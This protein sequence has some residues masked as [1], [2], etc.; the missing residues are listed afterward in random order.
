MITAW[1]CAD[2]SNANLVLDPS[3]RL[4]LTRTDVKSLRRLDA[5]VFNVTY[6]IPLAEDDTSLKTFLFRVELELDGSV[7]YV[8]QV[9][10]LS[11]SLP[12]SLPLSLSISI[13]SLIHVSIIPSLLLIIFHSPVFQICLT[14]ATS[15]A[16]KW[17]SHSLLLTQPALKTASSSLL[18]SKY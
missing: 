17:I 18:R 2:Y 15:L 14:W 16:S 7:R 3:R 5:G 9:C 4:I 12:L 10:N 8:V 6:D 1:F 11:F 13:L